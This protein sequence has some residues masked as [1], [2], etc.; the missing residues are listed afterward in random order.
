MI[1]NWVGKRIKELRNNKR[2]TQEQLALLSE[3]DRTYIASVEK[4]KRNISI[5]NL[6]KISKALEISLEEF[7]KNFSWEWGIKWAKN[8]KRKR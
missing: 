5:I 6:Y 8:L 2:L 7:F 3:L 4:G 1:T